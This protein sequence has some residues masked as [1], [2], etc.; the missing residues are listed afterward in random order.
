MDQCREAQRKWCQVDNGLGTLWGAGDDRRAYH[1]RLRLT[2]RRSG[3]AAGVVLL[4]AF[5]LWSAFDL[6]VLPAR[7][8]G[9]I[10]IR[11]A[12]EVPIAVA[13]LALWR[14]KVGGGWPE[15]TAFLLLPFPPPPP[16]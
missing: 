7:A 13:L 16:P 12:F 6:L 3:L 15:P 1:D 11:A 5:P 10:G 4:I 14:P 2:T 9:F 8:P